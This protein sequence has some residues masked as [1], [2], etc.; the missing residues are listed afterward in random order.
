MTTREDVLNYVEDEGVKFIRLGF[1]DLFG[2]QRN[3]SIMP[4]QLNRAFEKGV[5]ID[6]SQVFPNCTHEGT[7]LII[8]PDPSTMVLLPWRSMENGVIHMVCDLYTIDG[9]P[10]EADTRRL[11]K[12]VLH[13]VDVA[14]LDL[15]MAAKNEFYLFERDENGLPTKKPFDHG[16]YMDVAPL[17]QGE[18]IRREICM[19]L[20]E[21]GLD[22]HKSYHQSGPG[23]NEIDFHFSDPLQAADEASL[24]KWVVRTTANANGLYADFSAK[25]LEDEAGSSMHVQV[26]FVEGLEKKEA[27]IAG[28][29]KYLP[30]MQLF[31]CSSPM[32][33]K[34]L[35]SW[36]AP[37][38]FDVSDTKRNVMVRIPPL[39]KDVIE[40]RLPDSLSNPYLNFTLVLIA[41]LQG[42]QENLDL[43]EGEPLAVAASLKEAKDLARNSKLLADSIHEDILNAYLAVEEE[44]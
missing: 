8:K 31:M 22:P 17:D 20:E 30:E 44:C 23:Q 5:A 7:D 33:V 15:L 37:S 13:D 27:F 14:G 19:I 43:P 18:N 12:Q 42:I 6:A 25:P 21:M 4:R 3:I 40:V 10:F 35:A 28:L 11:L 24:F 1:Y 39:A 32:S 36:N 9:Q 38:F 41:G 16:G 29:L 34:R 2:K 26:R